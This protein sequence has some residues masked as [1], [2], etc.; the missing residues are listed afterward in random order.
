MENLDFGNLVKKMI[1]II[2][3]FMNLK[4]KFKSQ[5]TLNSSEIVKI[6]MKIIQ[7]I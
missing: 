5:I 2:K 6:V 4:K 7:M 3:K 1:L